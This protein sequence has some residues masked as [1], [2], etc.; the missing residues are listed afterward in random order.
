MKILMGVIAD[1]YTGA[2][3]I[4]SE[5][6]SQGVPVCLSLGLPEETFWQKFKNDWCGVVVIGLKTRMMK[7][8]DACLYSKLAYKILKEYGAERIYDKYCSTMDST[9][10]GNIGPVLDTL[11]ELENLTYTLICPSFIE[12]GRSVA[13]GVLY[14]EGIPL[15]ES[16]MKNHP[17]TPM[18]YSTI[19]DILKHQSQYP[20]Y[21]LPLSIIKDEEALK[22]FIAEKAVYSKH[23]YIIPDYENELDGKLLAEHF[24]D[25]PLLSGASG[26]AKEI[27]NRLSDYKNENETIPNHADT[28]A[29]CGS[30]SSTT[31]KQ[32]TFAKKMNLPLLKLDI[33]KSTDILLDKALAFIQEHRDY[34]IIYTSQSLE[35]RKKDGKKLNAD[36]IEE[37]FAEIAKRAK[38]AGIVNFIVCG[39]ETSGAVCNAI[40]Y[41]EF[42][43]NGTV[44][45]G[46][47]ILIPI[48]NENMRI[49]LKSGNFGSENFLYKAY[50]LING[51]KVY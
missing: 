39:G 3:D 6:Q 18:N 23:F 49:V 19:I 46:V 2:S 33:N 21:A 17:L 31:L 37:L 38:L 45:A 40:N 5:I 4:A 28:L 44:D 7:A 41:N 43:L 10:K 47:P 13:K 35:E 22:K 20:S 51:K 34:S 14:V 32:I 27:A 26:L 24:T 1:D 50:M 16:S 25:Y 42:H 48:Q 30:C 11:L 12:N 36:E 29:L 9:D 15:N 8:D